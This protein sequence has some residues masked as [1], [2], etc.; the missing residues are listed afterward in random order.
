MFLPHWFYGSLNNVSDP[1]KALLQISVSLLVRPNIRCLRD[2]KGLAPATEPL[3][4]WDASRLCKSLTNFV[5]DGLGHPK[6]ISSGNRI[7]ICRS[8]LL[9]SI[10]CESNTL[11]AC[12][13]AKGIGRESNGNALSLRFH[14][15]SK[16][17]AQRAIVDGAQ[18]NIP[19][20]L[21]H[22]IGRLS[23]GFLCAASG[24]FRCTGAVAC[25][26]Q[27]LRQHLLFSCCSAVFGTR[28]VHVLRHLC[29]NLFCFALL[30]LLGRCCIALQLLIRPW[31]C[32]DI[33]A[34]G[35]KALPRQKL[36][37][38]CSAILCIRALHVSRLG[39]SSN[40][41]SNCLCFA[42]PWDFL[43]TSLTRPGRG[44]HS[45]AAT[46]ARP[47]AAAR[48]STRAPRA[49][50]TLGCTTSAPSRVAAGNHMAL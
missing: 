38:S 17:G 42:D 4:L 32:R 39:F 50:G 28:D 47:S 43:G 49:Q 23:R 11:F 40:L 31:W 12:D 35:C 6:A 16:H 15:R 27:A 14:L 2:L 34:G 19:R 7:L 37:H 26:H 9:E 13:A 36:V 20:V 22:L 30:L 25:R 45:C 48:T 33:V 1:L 29:S 8:S 3:L 10:G 21:S 5:N 46:G 41:C 18:Q 44:K 24:L